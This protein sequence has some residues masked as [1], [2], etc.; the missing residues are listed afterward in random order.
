MTLARRV[1][2]KGALALALAARCTTASTPANAGWIASRS[3]MSAWWQGTPGTARRFSARKAYF[4]PRW[5]STAPPMSPLIPVTSTAGRVIVAP[6]LVRSALQL[7]V[8]AEALRAGW[9][10]AEERVAL[11]EVAWLPRARLGD[12]VE[13]V[14]VLGEASPRVAHVV[15]KVRADDVADEAPAPR[16]AASI[17]CA[18]IAISS[19]LPTSNEPWWKPGPLDARNARLWW[20]VVQRRNAMIRWQRSESFNPSTRV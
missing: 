8:R 2:S 18:P 12:V 9:A 1:S 7:A 14:V 19:T 5:S 6:G 15:E 13:V 11:G 3:A 10:P 20:S 4:A 16:P 17:R